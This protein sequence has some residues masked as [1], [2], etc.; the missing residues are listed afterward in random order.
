MV[1]RGWADPKLRLLSSLPLFDGLGRT[2]LRQLT[3]HLDEVELAPGDVLVE[4]GTFQRA[5]YL[6]VEGTVD[7]HREHEPAGTLGAGSWLG[8]RGMLHRCPATESAVARTRGRALVVSRAQ[9]R[10]LKSHPLV[11]GKLTGAGGR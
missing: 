5:L 10:A 6:L 8:E 1:T 7:V 4:R 2:Q 3:P 11:V 9:F